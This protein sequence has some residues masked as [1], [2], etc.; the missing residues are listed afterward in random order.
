MNMSAIAAAAAERMRA[1]SSNLIVTV[2]CIY[3]LIN[4][5]NEKIF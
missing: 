2:F 4:D 5:N 1:C 3:N